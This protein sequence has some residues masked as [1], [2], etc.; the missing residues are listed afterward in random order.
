MRYLLRRRLFLLIG[1]LTLGL[2]FLVA[3]LD[4]AGETRLAGALAG[5]MRVLIVPM[6]L[7]WLVLTMA[8]VA[9]AGPGGLPGPFA[10]VLSG[11]GFLAGLAPYALADYV[12]D[13]WR[14]AAVQKRDRLSRGIE[15]P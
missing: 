5:P 9:L 2:F 3:A 6:Y 7:V 12:L 14:R 11:I 10:A 8:L 1:P 15:H 13:R 4:G